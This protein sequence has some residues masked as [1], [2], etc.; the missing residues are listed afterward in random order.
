[1]NEIVVGVD[2][3]PGGGR[4]LRWAVEAARLRGVA[5]RAVLA[6][7]P[8]AVDQGV[9]VM[10]REDLEASAALVMKGALEQ[11]P[12]GDP[13][14]TV[15]PTTVYLAPVEALLQESRDAA[16][17]VLGA[18]GHGTFARLL[19]GSVS[20]ACVH[21]AAV[22]VVVIRRLPDGD[23]AAGPVVVGVDGSAS[24]IAALRWA[25]DEARV[26]TTTLRVLHAWQVIPPP[27][28]GLVHGVD[29]QRSELAARRVLNESLQAGLAGAAGVEVD[30][31]VIPG[32]ASVVLLG[33]A[34]QAQ[35][36]V[37]GSRG[38]G[39][40]AE[41]LLGSTSHQCVQHAPGPVV[42]VR[43]EGD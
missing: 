42:V 18:R 43:A 32:L 34:R 16:M 7:P 29:E 13:P 25:A 23:A 11:V 38:H 24:S 9:A 2:G 20:H 10:S 12:A 39:G 36:L 17:L 6:W 19:V 14:V 5:V 41:L 35:L 26:R 21:H 8:E 1:M 31:D 33:A 15:E 40:F 37:V 30:A 4:A 3:S 27:Y 28:L 22:P